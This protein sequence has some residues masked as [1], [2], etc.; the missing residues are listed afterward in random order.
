MSIDMKNV[1]SITLGGVSV[2][3]IEDTSGNILW[4]GSTTATM[5]I[6][7]GS[8]KDITT[9]QYYN[10]IVLPSLST[11]KSTL[12]SKIGVTSSSINIT[13]VELDE[14][15]LYW[16]NPYTSDNS[17]NAKATTSSSVNSGTTV[18]VSDYNS[19][20]GAHQW[21][22]SKID[23]TNYLGSKLYGYYKGASGYTNFGNYSSSNSGNFCTSNR[24]VKPEFTL[25][26]TYEY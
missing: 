24:T 6:T 5:N 1:K 19:T 3:K 18:L 25:V 10:R 2:N 21:G 12:E 13:K 14:S 4:S 11:I 17:R 9:T 22:T 7:V 20:Q 8:G 15:T 16:Y 23:V 26:V